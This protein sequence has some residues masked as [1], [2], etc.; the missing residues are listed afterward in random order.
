MYIHVRPIHILYVAHVIWLTL[1]LIYVPVYHTSG[2]PVHTMGL[3]YRP[4][5]S[6]DVGRGG[7]TPGKNPLLPPKRN[8][9][10]DMFGGEMPPCLL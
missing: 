6:E 8:P 1:T 7:I 10:K 2:T 9:Y 3:S 5:Y 4:L